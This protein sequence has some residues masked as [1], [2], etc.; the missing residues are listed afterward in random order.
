LAVSLPRAG[1]QTSRLHPFD[2]GKYEKDMVKY[3]WTQGS[4]EDGRLV[5]MPWDIGPAGVWYRADIMEKLGLSSKPEE[6]EALIS[7]TKGKKWEDFFTLSQQV[8]ERAAARSRWLLMQ[9]PTS[10]VVHCAKAAKVTSKG[11]KLMIEEKATRPAQL[12]ADYRKQG[13][14]ANIAWWGADWPLVSK[15]MPSPV[16]LSPAGCKVD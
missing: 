5:A 2:G 16:W 13:L 7:H 11:M 4:T 14:D 6:V 15:T 1:C 12:A 3:K 10:M 9:P 8:K